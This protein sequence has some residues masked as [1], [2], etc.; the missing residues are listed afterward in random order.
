MEDQ[1]TEILKDAGKQILKSLGD[2]CLFVG[3]T[4]RWGARPP[5]RW[6]H[7][8]KQFEFIGVKSIPI[9]L[10]TSLFTGMV[11]ALQ[12][13][14][15]LALVNMETM[16][17]S[18]VGISLAREIAPVFAALMVVARVCSAMA[19]EIGSM[20]VTEQIDALYTMAVEPIQYLVVPRVLGCIVMVPLLTMVFTFVGVVGSYFVGVYLLQIPEGPF[21]TKLYWYVDADDIYLG[22]IKAAFFG[23]FI[24]TISCF[25]G[26]YTKGGAQGVGRATTQSVAASSVT[27]LVVDY[28]L[29]SWLL[30]YFLTKR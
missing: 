4:I 18:T 19:A 7:I 15:T 5:V 21:L 22:L 28:F 16:T 6:H 29:T 17:G 13:G 24:A 8:F 11:F 25:Q 1:K 27:V 3:E 23:F 20:R 26:F 9:I 12:A 10:L 14:R 30:E 2:W